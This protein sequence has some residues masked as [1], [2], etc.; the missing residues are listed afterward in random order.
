MPKKTDLPRS[1]LTLVCFVAF[2]LQGVLPHPLDAHA[3]QGA[4]RSWPVST[5][6]NDNLFSVGDDAAATNDVYVGFD[7]ATSG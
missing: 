6:G 5:P 4:V 2:A 1:M 7:A 3:A